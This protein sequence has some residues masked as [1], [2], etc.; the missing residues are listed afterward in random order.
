[1]PSDQRFEDRLPD[2]LR[3]AADHFP[4]PAPDLVRGATARAQRQ[5]RV[6]TAQAGAA[7]ALTLVAI[8]TTLLVG[9]SLGGHRGAPQAAA[10][11]AEQTVPVPGEPR[12]PGPPVSAKELVETF[13]SL[14]PP[15]Q[16][17]VESPPVM[18]GY[19][20]AQ[21]TYTN[22]QG[23]SDLR[24]WL[25]RLTPGIPLDEQGQGNCVPI[26]DR[27]YDVCRT[28][29]LPGGSTLTTNQSHA[30][31][32]DSASQKVWSAV[33]TSKEGAQVNVEEF[34]GGNP[35]KVAATG[36]LPV[37]STDQLAVIARSPAWHKALDS[38]PTPA[39]ETRRPSHIM[40][41]PP[42]ARMRSA[43]VALLPRGG[44]VSD[45]YAGSGAAEAV[46][47]DGHGKNMFE[48]NVQ[49][50]MAG[51]L[52]MNCADRNVYFCRASQL[53]DGTKVVDTK[54]NTDSDAVLWTADVLYPDGH[55]VAVQEANSYSA[56]GPVTRPQPVLDL[57]RLQAMA[58]SPKWDP[59]H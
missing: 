31:P 3:L 11:D 37:L 15:G 18:P 55:R 25:S 48:V 50:D 43:L 41:G 28:V 22:G 46:F 49:T 2:A 59:K 29:P 38:I 13:K 23:T 14:L 57:D 21:I 10:I 19:R 5:R 30:R 1:M 36:V 33:V 39:T 7:A 8:G 32:D 20:T 24:L 47:D 52:Q 44:T 27:P 26:E 4:P 58:L 35:D 6:R 45:L 17:T 51:Q 16:V 53:P 34:A 42:E 40:Q 9:G 12:S 56:I 54:A